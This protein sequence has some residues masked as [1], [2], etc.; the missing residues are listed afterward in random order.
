MCVL[1]WRWG[2]SGDGGGGDVMLTVMRSLVYQTNMTFSTKLH[3]VCIL[4]SVT[5]LIK[6]KH[7][8]L[9]FNLHK[10]LRWQTEAKKKKK[11]SRKEVYVRSP[12]LLGCFCPFK[13]Y[14]SPAKGSIY[15]G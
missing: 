10:D 8:P 11:K 13:F 12:K 3:Q 1:D 4:G 2:G 15:G 7:S 14:F 5:S 6:H 9:E